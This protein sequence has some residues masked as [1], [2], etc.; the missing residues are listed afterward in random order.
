V[1]FQIPVTL[2]ASG[3]SH[4]C[5]LLADGTVKCWGSNEFGQLGVAATLGQTQVVGS[6]VQAV[7][8]GGLPVK[9]IAA[10]GRHTCAVVTN[11]P[12]DE[13][14]CWGANDSGQLG[15]TLAIGT[16]SAAPSLA[17]APG[18]AIT[19]VAAGDAHTCAID[20]SQVVSC[21]GSNSDGQLGD[22]T[23]L[24][25]SPANG[26]NK[27][28][29]AVGG[30]VSAEMLSL[31]M[32]TSC[33]LAFTGDLWC[34]GLNDSAQLQ[35]DPAGTPSTPNPRH[36]STNM[37]SAGLGRHQ[38]CQVDMST[39]DWSCWGSN[40]SGELGVTTGL[41]T[42][43]PVYSP[44]AALGISRDTP[45]GTAVFGGEGFTCVVD[46]TGGILCFGRNDVGQLGNGSVIS[47]EKPTLVPLS[48]TKNYI[49]ALGVGKAHACAAVSGDRKVA[50]WG[51]NDHGQLGV[52]PAGTPYTG[53]PVYP[54][55]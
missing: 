46:G 3:D 9:F 42:S 17:F 30:G 41:G 27:I 18:M 23:T 54:G 28:P 8:L 51:S 16:N 43:T 44:P 19:M 36:I 10:G 14:R 12:A 39:N 45:D 22:P 20:N 6:Q 40:L 31:S 53:T 52:D 34:W 15:Q 24:P 55:L 50:C 1:T 35:T 5:A 26:K 13:V 33:A 4:T 21:W 48:V 25:G 7:P 11:G 49:P 32:N 47:S 29:T 37:Q 2:V 38:A